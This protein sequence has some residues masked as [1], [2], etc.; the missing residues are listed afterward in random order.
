MN[1]TYDKFGMVNGDDGCLLNLQYHLDFSRIF[2][3]R[4]SLCPLDLNSHQMKI[5]GNSPV[6]LTQPLTKNIS[7]VSVEL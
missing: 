1:A 4:S 2:M 3:F 7:G 5:M 6:Q